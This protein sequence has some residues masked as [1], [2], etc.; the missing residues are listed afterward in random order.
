VTE[1]HERAKRPTWLRWLG[2]GALI[3]LVGAVIGWAASTVFTPPRDVLSST[4]FTTVEV[5]DGEVGSSITLNTVAEWTP[6]PVGSNQA[7]GI[8]TSVKVKAGSLVKPGN[9]LYTVDLRPV[10]IAKGAVPSFR[11]LGEGDTGA[12]VSQL[13]RMLKSAGFSTAGPTGT[14]SAVTTTGVKSWQKA[15]GMDATGIVQAGDI[16]YVPTLPTRVALDT[17]LVSRGATLA[18]GEKVL[19]GLPSSPEF[20]IPVTDAQAAIM[21]E[22]TRIEI[23]APEGGTWDGFVVARETD[24]ESGTRVILDGADGA[25][26]CGESCDTIAVEGQTFLLSTIVTVETVSGLTV[27]SAALRSMADGSIAVTDAEGVDYPVTVVT[28][29]RGMSI[30]EGVEA[31]LEVRVPATDE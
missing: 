11:S 28:S 23:T 13:Q 12:D 17:T 4:S 16:I 29:A 18:G 19:T 10:V 7:S 3:L 24:E 21:P 14:F 20:A 8:V 30:I 6:I 5:V 26:I 15:R 9:T 25:A 2:L 27:P 22:G 1:T 31:G